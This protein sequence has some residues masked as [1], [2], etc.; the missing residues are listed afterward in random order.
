MYCWVM[1]ERALLDLARGVVGQRGPHHALG[2]DALVGPELA[3]LV[4]DH[5]V[6]QVGGHLRLGHGHAQVE[7]AERA[8]HVAGR[9][10]DRAGL[11]RLGR[12]GL[13]EG[14]RQVHVQQHPERGAWPPPPPAAGTPTTVTTAARRVGAQRPTGPGSRAAPAG[15]RSAGLTRPSCRCSWAIRGRP[16][17][18][19]PGPARTMVGPTALA[20]L[21]GAGHVDL[22]GDRA[23]AAVAGVGAGRIGTGGRDG[24]G[25]PHRQGQ[26]RGRRLG[27]RHRPGTPAAGPT[28]SRWPWSRWP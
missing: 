15:A 16:M 28:P 21:P 22:V 27:G 11:G 6:L 18:P 9:V 19:R 1:V 2:I 20:R 25:A 17:N 3:V 10:V 5:R 7:L 24:E 14:A 23:A 12:S 26:H 8:D 13:G 4:G